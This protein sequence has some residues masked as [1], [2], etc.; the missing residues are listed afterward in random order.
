VAQQTT[1]ILIRQQNAQTAMLRDLMT[2]SKSKDQ[3]SKPPP[4]VETH[5]TTISKTTSSDSE[6]LKMKKETKNPNTSLIG[7]TLSLSTKER[8]TKEKN[9]KN[10]NFE[11]IPSIDPNCASVEW[12]IETF[13]SGLREEIHL[14]MA[15]KFYG[16]GDEAESAA[17]E[18]NHTLRK[19]RFRLVKRLCNF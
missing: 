8:R 1:N 15:L 13:K 16:S 4:V 5:S 10:S 2:L 3:Q 14:K 12:M 7:N 17:L 9:Y 11:P 6:I 18:F 19:N